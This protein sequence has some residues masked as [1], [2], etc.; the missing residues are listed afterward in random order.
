MLMMMLMML[1]STQMTMIREINR[2]ILQQNAY[3]L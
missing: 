3:I 2:Y 1:M